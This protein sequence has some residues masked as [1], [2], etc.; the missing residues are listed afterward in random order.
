MAKKSPA[1]SSSSLDASLFGFGALL[2]A[3]Y[4]LVAHAAGRM[5]AALFPGFRCA[6]RIVFD[7]PAALL[8]A[9]VLAF[10]ARSLILHCHTIHSL[11]TAPPTHRC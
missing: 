9:F 3:L 11:M 6:L 5:L 1:K 7:V 10:V 2:A 8:A 4:M